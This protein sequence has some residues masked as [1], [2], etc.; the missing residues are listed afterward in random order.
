MADEQV[1]KL[2][3]GALKAAR[4]GNSEQARKAFLYVIKMQPTN[5]VA[6]MGLA[7]VAQDQREQVIALQKAVEINP[8]NA[9]AQ[10]ALE[11]ILGA[12]PP[13]PAAP[14][15]QRPQPTP[16]PRPTAPPPPVQE[17]S[18][19]DEDDPFEA[20]LSDQT[21]AEDDFEA[22]LNDDSAVEESDVDEF[23]S[24]LRSDSASVTEPSEA[25]PPT[26]PAP[27][28][29][30]PAPTS[31]VL[32]ETP[33]FSQLALTPPGEEGV[34][35]PKR[36]VLETIT[37]QGDS[38]VNAYLKQDIDDRMIEWERKSRGRAGERELANLRLRVF[39]G[40]VSF[41]V[42]VMFIT[43]AVY[44]NSPEYKKL[45]FAPTWTLSPTLTPTPSNTPGATLTAS[46][47]P[48]LS[49]TPSPTLDASVTPGRPE[50]IYRPEATRVYFPPGAQRSRN[51]EDAD[52]LINSG[53]T[54]GA[55]AKI[56]QEEQ[57]TSLTGDFMPYYYLA[58]I[59][60]AQGD[61]EAAQQTVTDGRVRWE[62]KARDPFYE[63]LVRLSESWLQFNRL[64]EQV[65]GGKTV[66][67][68]QKSFDELITTVKNV[69]DVSQNFDEPYLLLADIYRFQ[70]NYTTA[71]QTLT[72]AQTGNGRA[73]L[74][75]NT[76]LRLKKAEIYRDMGQLDQA[77]FELDDLLRLNPFEEAGLR[78]RMEI[79]KQ[80]GNPGLVVIYAEA[81]QYYYP[82]NILG[83]RMMG[84][85]FVQE[86]KIG[87]AMVQYTR[88]LQGNSSD[89]DYANALAS[90]A[91]VYG[92]QERD[93]LAIQDLTQAIEIQPK[94]MA[95][96]WQR[97]AVAYRS[98]DY[99]LANEDLA[100]LQAGGDITKAQFTI[101]STR[102]LVDQQ[103][104]DANGQ[105][106]ALA[107]LKSL[108]QRDIPAD[109][110]P[111][112][113]ELIA[114]LEFALGN[115]SRALT[116]LDAALE[117]ND[118]ASRHVLRGEI[119]QAQ[120][121]AAARDDTKLPLYIAA[122]REYDFVLSWSVVYRYPFEAEVQTRY[123]TVT[124]EVVRLRTALAEEDKK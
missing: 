22:A 23:E 73:A 51:I 122:Q 53:D 13:A 15:P 69:A 3:Q 63:P 72:D 79:A 12:Q 66:K 56:E 118:T 74:F 16:P 85:A 124:A 47:T 43:A 75:A 2:L 57:A 46:P 55:I 104:L 32:P 115:E 59:Q 20:A 30:A 36:R 83:Y 28:V 8:Q 123:D 35:V 76:R 80:K 26:V 14:P 71:L 17:T 37:Q 100:A 60:I 89:P 34:P 114:R 19:E 9:R 24:A 45:V 84:D 41:L 10:A 49:P 82:E 33:L 67:S 106:A 1:Q 38:L 70:G 48:L 103:T 62:S 108:R 87:Q 92:S 7:T 25:T 31:P 102:I 121:D 18:Y 116:A 61:Y 86:N 105:Q 4:E 99:A 117:V 77:L 96:H 112:T 29:T 93:D 78:M 111:V 54:N 42:V 97:F 11:R 5:E 65:A 110:Q 119:L 50:V 113:N 90:R 107:D 27:P 101:L 98:K 40:T 94:T 95:F 64:R 44:V 52:A 68:L 120:A 58:R 109:L 91:A 6:W 21:A 39:G 88:A 81:Y